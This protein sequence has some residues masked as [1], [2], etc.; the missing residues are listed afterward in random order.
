M[1]T[2]SPPI[3]ISSSGSGGS[4]EPPGQPTRRQEG[5]RA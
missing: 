2:S 5:A 3:A 1:T 4:P